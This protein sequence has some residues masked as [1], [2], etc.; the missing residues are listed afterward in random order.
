[1]VQKR[2]GSV[3]VW[4]LRKCK[5]VKDRFRGKNSTCQTATYHFI[6]HF[7]TVYIES[8]YSTHSIFSI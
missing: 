7:S 2:V 5:A 6:E 1:M 3:A 8:T 4:T